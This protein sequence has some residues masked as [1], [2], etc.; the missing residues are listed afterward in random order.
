MSSSMETSINPGHQSETEPQHFKPPRA[1]VDGKK[2]IP[3]CSG[4]QWDGMVVARGQGTRGSLWWPVRLWD[5]LVC[6]TPHVQAMN[7]ARDAWN[8]PIVML[9]PGCVVSLLFHKD[10]LLLS[11][12][13]LQVALGM[14]VLSAASCWSCTGVYRQAESNLPNCC[15][16]YL[17]TCMIESKLPR[18]NKKKERKKKEKKKRKRKGSELIVS[19]FQERV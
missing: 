19:C 1:L 9:W 13:E 16:Y 7:G 17:L 5:V 2:M 11:L 6:V 15:A 8:V 14:D 12:P 18:K 4:T 10:N 3:F